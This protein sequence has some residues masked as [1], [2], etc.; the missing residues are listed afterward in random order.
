VDTSGRSPT[1]ASSLALG[2]SPEIE[3]V[4]LAFALPRWQAEAFAK[5]ASQSG[6]TAG[7]MLR[8]II[9]ASLAG[10]APAGM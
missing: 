3:V 7:Q 8:K 10:L 4:E 5:A 2:T 1:S 6:L 9:G